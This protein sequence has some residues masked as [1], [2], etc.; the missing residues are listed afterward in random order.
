[1]EARCRRVGR[2]LAVSPIYRGNEDSS[3]TRKVGIWID[4]R[5]AYI[6]SISATGEETQRLESGM[7][8]HVRSSGHSSF[9]KGPGENQR[10][11]QFAAHLGKYYDEVVARIRDADAIL[12]FGPGEAKGELQ[13]RLAGKGLAERILGVETVDKVTDPQFLA[14]VRKH[15]GK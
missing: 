2:I 1:M 13:K 6:V 12:L 9:A 11:R 10:D 8:K 7:E 4:H 5:D 3:M 15:F 14:M